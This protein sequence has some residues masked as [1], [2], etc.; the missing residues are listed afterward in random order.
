MEFIICRS[1]RITKLFAVE[2]YGLCH[3]WRY[4]YADFW[5][6]EELML[7]VVA[8]AAVISR[9]G[10]CRWQ[11]V[12]GAGRRACP[13]SLILLAN[14][15]TLLHTRV[16]VLRKHADFD[17]PVAPPSSHHVYRGACTSFS[18]TI[19]TTRNLVRRSYDDL[20]NI[21]ARLHT[22]HPA[23]RHRSKLLLLSGACSVQF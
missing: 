10:S 19:Y 3:G 11:P 13:V 5:I 1:H 23:G 17:V 18:C 9:S 14:F 20:L 2:S 8:R 15:V 7:L 12:G 21:E 22:F 6:Q 16:D 4:R